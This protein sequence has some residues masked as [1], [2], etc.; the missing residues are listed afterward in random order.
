MGTT[1]T[2]C[3]KPTLIKPFP[4]VNCSLWSVF[5]Q[6]KHTTQDNMA[7]LV[8]SPHGHTPFLVPEL[9]GVAPRH[10]GGLL[11]RRP[12]LARRRDPTDESRRAGRGGAH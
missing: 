12:S 1:A 7:F 5:K 4:S 9:P 8:D 2:E 10:P 6:N 11:F 3:S